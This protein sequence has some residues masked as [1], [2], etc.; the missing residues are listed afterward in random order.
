[1]GVGSTVWRMDRPPRRHIDPF[2]LG[3]LV[4]S[5]TLAAHE[6]GYFIGG[7][8][9]VSHAYFG[10]VGPLVVL[11][12]CVAAWLAAVRILRHDSGRLP[13][14][15]SLAGMQ[16][17]VFVGMEVAE[18]V[19]SDSLASLLSAPVVIGLVLQP[20]VALVAKQLLTAGRRFVESFARPVRSARSVRRLVDS[21]R[22]VA[23]PVESLWFVRLRLRGP[24]V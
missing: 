13:S 1:M 5:G 18:R 10:I 19:A 20:L 16:V 21:P 24:P 17:L 12:G 3:A 6:I 23:V 9:S 14:V 2:G 4:A 22:P 15:A 11:M 8:G 7:S